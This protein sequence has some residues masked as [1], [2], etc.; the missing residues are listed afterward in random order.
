MKTKS[1]YLLCFCFLLSNYCYLCEYDCQEDDEDQE[2]CLSVIHY[3]V[4][5]NFYLC[6]Y[7]G[8][9]ND[10]GEYETAFC[11]KKDEESESGLDCGVVNEAFSGKRIADNGLCESIRSDQGK[12]CSYSDGACVLKTCEQLTKDCD[13]LQYCGTYE[14]KCKINDCRGLTHQLDCQNNVLDADNKLFCKWEINNC[15]KIKCNERSS[16]CLFLEPSG[17]EDYKCFSDG[18]KC[19]EANS[20]ENVEVKNDD[21]LSSICSQ[22]PHCSPG[23][24]NDCTNNCNKIASEDECNYAL[25]DDKT[26]I[27]CKWNESGP[28]GKKCQVDGYTEITSCD[29]AKNSNDI[30]NEQCSI[31]NVSQGNNYCRKGPDGCFEFKDCDDIKVKVDSSICLELTKPEDELQCIP[32][33]ENGCKKELVQCLEY[34]LYIYNKSICEKLN[35]SMEDYKCFSDGEKCIEANSCD[36]I[37]DTTYDTNSADLKKICDLFDFCE[38]YEKGCKTKITPTTIDTILETEMPTTY[39]SNTI[40]FTETTIEPIESSNVATIPSI[41]QTT[42]LEI[43]PTTI[44]N[45]LPDSNTEFITDTEKYEQKTTQILSNESSEIPQPQNSLE[46]TIEQIASTINEKTTMTEIINSSDNKVI[47]SLSENSE[48]QKIISTNGKDSTIINS[49]ASDTILSQTQND[50]YTTNK[51]IYTNSTNIINTDTI[52]NTI[53]FYQKNE[54][55]TLAIL[56]GINLLRLYEFYFSFNIYFLPVKNSIFSY[57][58]IFPITVLY[59]S[60]IRLLLSKEFE[61]NCNLIKKYIDSKYEYFCTVETE[62]KNIKQIKVTPKFNFTSQQ[63]VKIIGE[64]PIAKMYMNNLL[65]IDEKFDGL[66]NSFIYILDNCTLEQK[67]NKIFDISGSMKNPLDKLYKNYNLTIM[68]N[69]ESTDRSEME[70]DCYVANATGSNYTLSCNSNEIFNADFQSSIS[71]LDNN[72]ILLI[73]FDYIEYY[74]N[75]S[76]INTNIDSLSHRYFKKNENSGKAVYIIIISLVIALVIFVVLCVLCIYL[77]QKGKIGSDASNESSITKFKAKDSEIV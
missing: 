49:N 74:N 55:E 14:G 66:S 24:N 13:S 53:P 44:P 28:T 31:L 21:V 42:M 29:D 1:A 3:D 77:R 75:N 52:N 43:E 51:D 76:L 38:P 71:F 26:F 47:S 64:T 27:K 20:C 67:N 5:G 73:N 63:N 17:G 10:Y 56:L 4:Y 19:V 48:T 18:E 61:G 9:V 37:K 8:E 15:R 6:R 68:M 62:T 23:K 50:L 7:E 40:E 25:K 34:S 54:E 12:K 22:F 36:S 57:N 2:S 65:L 30:K 33:G 72:T 69:I 60:N 39:K 70:V 59:N 16:D 58:L 32:N 35:V 11:L 46:K 45:S 41:S